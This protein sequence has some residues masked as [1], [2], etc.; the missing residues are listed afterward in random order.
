MSR[1]APSI[2]L[3][4]DERAALRKLVRSPSAEHRLV[5]R[6]RIVLLADECYSNQ[7]IA[8]TLKTRE[9]RVSKWRAR[10]ARDRTLGLRDDARG[11]APAK[12]DDA[13]ER[14]ILETLDTPPPS[15]YATWT[16]GLV[17]RALGNVSDDQVWRV[18]RNRNISLQRRRSWCISNDPD[19][20]AKAA[21]IVGLYLDPPT[22]AL[23]LSVDEKP[24]ISGIGRCSR[25]ASPARRHGSHRRLALLQAAWHDDALR[26]PGRGDRQG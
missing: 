22:N 15:G 21:D 10:F 8:E 4:T 19:F 25:M 18:L 20:A 26:G 16:G 12:Y 23:V 24:S 9:A 11:G 1:I 5:E 6:A 2:E 13:T 17:A 3:T 7:Q 14:R